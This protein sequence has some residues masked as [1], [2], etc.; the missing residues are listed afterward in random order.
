M[1][2]F[3][4]FFVSLLAIGATGVSAL[5][6]IQPEAS[7]ISARS[8]AFT[9]RDYI[10]VERMTNAKRLAQGQPPL[11]PRRRNHAD[12]AARTKPSASPT[13]G[14][15]LT[16]SIQITN[17]RTGEFLGYVGKTYQLYGEYGP[18]NKLKNALKVKIPGVT[19][20]KSGPLQII[21]K[22]GDNV[23]P[24]VGAIVGYQNTDAAL[25]E[26]SPNYVY[27]GGVAQTAPGATPQ[28]AG[29]AFYQATGIQE[30]VESAVWFFNTNNRKITFGWVNPDGTVAQ[31]AKLALY[32]PDNVLIAVG[33]LA[34]FKDE[35]GAAVPVTFTLVDD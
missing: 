33:D 34:K 29:S 4:T 5:K 11:P 9:S 8:D 24:N 23:Y 32:K 10:D 26:G 16:G 14:R 20:G 25:S 13:P 31:A 7:K 28:T 3:S 6:S 27:I 30:K 12:L 18:V 22:N 2:K 1:V 19:N 35:F 17:S 21:G 15:V